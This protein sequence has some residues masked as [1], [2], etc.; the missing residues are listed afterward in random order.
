MTLKK[1]KLINSVPRII[2]LEEHGSYSMGFLTPVQEMKQVPFLIRRVFWTHGANKE[3][4]RGN[5]AHKETE[6]VIVAVNGTIEV[7]VIL[8][9]MKR[10][11]FLLDNPCQGLYLP[12]RVWRTLYFSKG[13][14]SI[15][16]AS[17]DYDPDD[18][19]KDMVNW[20]QRDYTDEKFYS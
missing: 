8:E 20:L 5:H 11:V 13:A 14:I 2:E 15:T 9:D 10:Q 18:Y 19:E 7:E 6:E 12:P 17:S 3:T 4:V 1:K 16:L